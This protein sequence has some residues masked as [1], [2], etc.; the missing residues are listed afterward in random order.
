MNLQLCVLEAVKWAKQAFE[1]LLKQRGFI[2]N[3]KSNLFGH[4][5]FLLHHLILKCS[6]LH[7]F[8][9]TSKGQNKL[10]RFVPN[11]FYSFPK[12]EPA[13]RSFMSELLQI[14]IMKSIESR[15]QSVFRCILTTIFLKSDRM[16]FGGNFEKS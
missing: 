16:R 7:F 12:N 15:L 10:D 14:A 2:R 8:V 5:I 3:A 11:I 4:K 9:N 13:Y 6:P 1:H